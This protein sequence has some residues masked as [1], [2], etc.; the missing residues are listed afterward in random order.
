MAFLVQLA[1][2]KKQTQKSIVFKVVSSSSTLAGE[3]KGKKN[4][5]KPC[6]HHGSP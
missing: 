4:N 5:L 3:G 1:T 2:K 6:L